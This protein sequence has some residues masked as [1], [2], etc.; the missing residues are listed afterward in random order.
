MLPWLVGIWVRLDV[1]YKL[2]NMGNLVKD[3]VMRRYLMFEDS[4][5]RFSLRD[6]SKKEMVRT[7]RSDEKEIQSKVEFNKLLLT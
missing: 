3:Y 6:V 2:K 1:V 5:R 7:K 4:R